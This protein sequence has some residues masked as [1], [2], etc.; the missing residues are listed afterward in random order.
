VRQPVTLTVRLTPLTGVLTSTQTQ[1]MAVTLGPL[2]SYAFVPR[3]LATVPGEHAELTLTV[4][5]APSA[6]SMSRRRTYLVILSPAVAVS[7][8]FSAQPGDT[9]PGV[10]THAR[11]T[12]VDAFGNPVAG[13]VVTLTVASGP[14]GF[15]TSSTLIATT[16]TSGVAVFTKLVLEKAGAYS[17]SATDGSAVATSNGFAVS[18]AAG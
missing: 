10:A 2:S 16:N 8:T 6:P 9:A 3:L 4:R 13:D 1:T 7:A 12:V 17:L 11:V 14:G 15:T 5:G 18:N